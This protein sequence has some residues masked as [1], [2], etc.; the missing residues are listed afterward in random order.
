MEKKINVLL[1]YCNFTKEDIGQVGEVNPDKY[2]CLTP[3]SLIPIV[4]E[5]EVLAAKPDYLIVL[6]W[7][8]RSFFITNPKYRG[9][10]L[11]FPLPSIEVFNG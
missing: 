5:E 9:Q 7:H 2:G 3:G 8:F 6:P 11:V 10:N 4:P 1:Q